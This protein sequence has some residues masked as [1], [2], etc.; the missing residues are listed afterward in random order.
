MIS[1]CLMVWLV[2]NLLHLMR[3][4]LSASVWGSDWDDG[5]L[6]AKFGRAPSIECVDERI[7][8]YK[9]HQLYFIFCSSDS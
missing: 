4:K 7:H 6:A 9:S 1:M 3:L 5:D 2:S 8:K